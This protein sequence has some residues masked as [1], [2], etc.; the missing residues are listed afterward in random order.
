MRVKYSD[1]GSNTE[2]AAPQ[3]LGGELDREMDEEAAEKEEAAAVVE[4]GG[5]I[6]QI[7]VE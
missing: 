1:D 7:L 5:Y 4:N 3:Y 6:L 2:I